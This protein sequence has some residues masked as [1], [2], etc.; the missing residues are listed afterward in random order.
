MLLFS[1]GNEVMSVLVGIIIGS[2]T[3]SDKV[4]LLRKEKQLTRG[5]E[6]ALN[7]CLL[8]SLSAAQTGC[9]LICELVVDNF[10]T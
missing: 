10:I 9:S 7:V 4:M 3:S 6:G 8:S 2:A 5:L 1:R